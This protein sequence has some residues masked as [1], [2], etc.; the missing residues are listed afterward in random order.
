MNVHALAAYGPGEILRPFEYETA[1]MEGHHCLIRVD[2]C[3]LCHSDIHCMDNDWEMTTYPIVPGHEAVGRVVEAGPLVSHLKVGDRVGVG[4][5]SGACLHCLDCLRGNAQMCEVDQKSTI[6]HQY[7]GFG[8]Y[9][10][11]DSRFAF[12]IPEGLPTDAA[13][14]LL[15][16]GITVYSGLRHAGMVGGQEIG[17]IGIGGLGHLAV[18]FAAKLGNRV[19]VFTSSPDKAEFAAQLGAAEAV[20][21]GRDGSVPQKPSRPL[22][23]IIDTV[24]AAKDYNAYLNCL[25]SDGVFN[26]VGVPTEPIALSVFA[27]QDKRRRIMGSPI[28]SPVEIIEMLALAERHAIVPI[29]ETYPFERANDAAQRLRDNKVRYR[30]VLTMN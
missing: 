30:A 9:L 6:I 14:P 1:L 5:Q 24:A 29:V 26:L 17:V 11:V 13:G 8:E 16:G 3:G 20:V 12:L 27:F 21:I 2:A 23:I 15:C 18:Q 4:W 19:S 25:A 7:G 28:G 10:A 22:D